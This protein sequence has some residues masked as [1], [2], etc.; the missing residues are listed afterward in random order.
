MPGKG[1]DDH[2]FRWKDFFKEL[3]T[4]FKTALKFFLGGTDIV[5]DLANGI[6]FI[7]GEYGVATYFLAGVRS[8]FP[9]E[10]FGPQIIFGVLSLSIVW[11]PGVFGTLQM[12]RETNWSR[13]SYWWR[14]NKVLFLL[15]VAAAWPLLNIAL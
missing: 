4:Q 14:M 1:V 11:I 7:T 8:D 12:A 9:A 2:G 15:I 5:T 10:E 13:L 6:N 3:W